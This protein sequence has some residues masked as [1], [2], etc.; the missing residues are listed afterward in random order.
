[1]SE[2]PPF[3]LSFPSV[4]DDIASQCDTA[5]Q[6]VLQAQHAGVVDAPAISLSDFSADTGADT[7]LNQLNPVRF[8]VIT[9][10]LWLLGYL[11]EEPRRNI[12][13]THQE[14][15]EFRDNL[16]R[17]QRDAGLSQDGWLGEK[18][19]KTLQELVSFETPIDTK[20]WQL[21]N[22]QFRTAFNRALQL[23]MWAY[24][25]MERK[26]AYNFAG[27]KEKALNDVQRMTRALCGS[28]NENHDWRTILLD[29][30][31]ILAGAIRTMD[32]HSSI[33]DKDKTAMRRLLISIARVELWLL[34]VEVDIDNTDDYAVENFSVKRRKVR[35]ADKLI[36]VSA[37]NNRLKNGLKQFWQELIGRSS[38][39]ASELCLNLSLCFFKSLQNPENFAEETDLFN[40]ADFSQN[41]AETLKTTEDI[42]VGYTRYRTLG[43]KLWDGVKR[44]WRWLVKG[45]KTIVQFADN[46]IRGFFRF[47]TKSYIIVRTALIALTSAIRQYIKGRID[48][49]GNNVVLIDKDFDYKMIVSDKENPSIAAEAIRRFSS[50]FLFSSKLVGLIVELLTSAIQGL[51]GWARFL[52]V[53]VKNYRDLV[54][55]Y[56]ELQEVS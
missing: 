36:W 31:K 5:L 49:T 9:K 46:L 28:E 40:E 25:F 8:H 29:S 55:A 26:P 16:R 23:R 39:Q 14:T 6:I 20:Y 38:E 18:T 34:G 7:R 44:I 48:K 52:Y 13:P 15:T 17:F 27:L 35:R 56:R 43:M 12:S 41:A 24:G 22:G 30:D 33:G 19:W 11:K 32:E 2:L 10:Q 47:A 51:L 45:V 1:V 4:G 37:T 50:S 54:P 53:L 42:K 21:P 3:Q